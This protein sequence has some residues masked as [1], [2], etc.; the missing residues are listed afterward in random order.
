MGNFPPKA[1]TPVR[2]ILEN[3]DQFDLQMLRKKLLIFFCGTAWPQY[4]LQGGETWLPKGSINYNSIL[5]LDLFCRKEGK[6]SEV[7]YVQTFFSLRDNSQLCKKCH[8][9]PTGSPQSLPPYPSIPLTPS[10][11]NKDPPST[12]MVQEEIDKGVNNEPKSAGIPQLCPLQAVGGG[13]FGPARAH[14]P[15]SLSDLKQIKIDLGKFSDNPDGYIDVLEGLGQSFDMT[16]RDIMLLLNQTL[17]PNE[18]SA[19]I[20]AA[21]EFGDLWYLSQLSDRM[22]TEERE[23]FLTGQQAVPSVDPHWDTESEHGDW[24]RRHLL[25]CALEGLRKTR[26]KPMNYSMMST[27]T[28]GKEEN[29]TA[30]LERLREALR[31][32]TSLSPDS[33]EGQLILKDKFITQSAADIRKKLQKLYYLKGQCRDCALVQLLIQSH[34]FQTMKKKIEHNCQQVIAQT[35]AARGDL[36]EVPLTDPHLN[37]YTNESSFVEKGLRKVGYAVVSDNG[38]LES[39]SLTP[40]TSTQLA[41]LIALT[42]ALELGEEKRMQSMTKIYCGPLDRPA[43]PCSDVNDIEGTPTEEISTVQPLLCPSSAGSS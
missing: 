15:F 14:V 36:P 28:Q 23:R 34:F 4:P 3:W 38:I 22:T 11:T 1:K 12:Q 6:W 10:P 21:R 43:S 24:C 7:P 29:P 8:L 32:H 19:A 20:T 40:G 39:N 18:R 30:F 26:K 37:L 9:C 5:Q 25:T 2:C 41:E 27:I 35:C 13:E 17:T 42:R 31:K 16:W 33:I